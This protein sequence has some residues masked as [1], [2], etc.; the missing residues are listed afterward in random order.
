MI[1]I[2]IQY[3]DGYISRITASGHSGYAE[4]GSDIVCAG[5]SALMIAIGN[6][7]EKNIPGITM[8]SL[9]DGHLDICATEPL[10]LQMQQKADLLF[11]TLAEGLCSLE[12]AYSAYILVTKLESK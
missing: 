10:S 6:G 8:H 2:V 3:N 4:A 5:V 11:N 1:N 7:L 12:E 9:E